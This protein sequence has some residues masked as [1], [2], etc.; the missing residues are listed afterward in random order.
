MSN[1]SI[2]QAKLAARIHDP[3]E[4]AL[5]LLRDPAGHEGGTVRKLREQLFPD[6]TWRPFQNMVKQADHWASAADRPQFPMDGDRYAAWT[7]V[8]FADQPEI[9]HPLT[10]ESFDPGTLHELEPAALKAISTDSFAKLV[11]RDGDVIAW[12]KTALAFWRFG[13]ELDAKGLKLLWQLL[14]ADTRVPDHTIWSHLD[15]TSALA[16]AMAGDETNTP[17]LLTVSFGPVQ[18]F[19]AQARSTSDLWAGSHLL[20]R[21]VWE[22]IRVI[23]ERLGPD[24]LLFPQLFGVP[25]VDA[26]ITDQLGGW[27]QGVAKADWQS[28]GTDANP[29]FAAALPNRFVAIVPAAQAK[30]IAEAVRDAA[31][32]WVM[33]QGEIM[34]DRLLKKAEISD[35][36]NAVEQV[37]RQLADFPE[38][39]WSAVPWSLAGE[40]NGEVQTDGLRDALAVFY[41]EAEAKSF[42][43][44]KA[45]KLLSKD[46]KVDG[47]WF[48]RPNAGVLYPPLYDLLERTQASVKTMRPFSPQCEEGYRCTLC[49]E[50]EW[51][52]PDRADLMRPAKK[53]QAV[54]WQK[55]PSSWSRKGKE[56]LCALCALK[57]LWPTLFADE[58]KQLTGKEDVPRFVVSTHTMA[59]AGD[60]AK[61]K[62]KDIQSLKPLFERYKPERVALPAK[63][64]ADMKQTS[65]DLAYIPGL[66]DAVCD[67]DERH[68]VESELKEWLGHKPETYYGFILFDGDK[69]GAWLQG[70]EDFTKRTYE[71]SWHT[72]VRDSVRE[73]ARHHPELQRY[74]K[75]NRPVSPARHAAISAALNGFALHLAR[76]AVEEAHHGKLIYAG[77]DDVMAMVPVGELLSCMRLLRLLYAGHVPEGV[78]LP[79]AMKGKVGSGFVHYRQRLLRVMGRKATASAGA[80]V[81]HHMMPLQRL[82]KTLRAAESEAKNKG[83]RDAF[84]LKVLKRGGGTVGSTARWFDESPLH[85]NTLS[86]HPVMMLEVLARTLASEQL[87]RRA[88][89]HV[90]AQLRQL[91]ER[92]HFKDKPDDFET[93]LKA[94]LARQF[95]QQGGDEQAQELAK[96]I[97][98][99]ACQTAKNNEANWLEEFF[100]VAEFLGREGRMGDAV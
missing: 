87:S 75:E 73:K 65:R 8:R 60:L 94:T 15:L 53:R 95:R 4:K 43:D 83:G 23:C 69:M 82:L 35:A 41:P 7:Q 14:P 86:K 11:Y 40:K 44:G 17:A 31:R 99:L 21:M 74:L 32:N 93:M 47:H 19:I 57:R 48:Y 56:H 70:N 64:A 3:A 10:G 2:W 61:N 45:W 88:A 72:Q 91:P 63:L 50:R 71:E 77:G 13:P 59:L 29:L 78:P 76:F 46:I 66:L 97:A 85:E 26:W 5:V 67:D 68:A 30:E 100:A 49:G 54:L 81:A 98:T 62:D 42:L 33:R 92:H 22:G 24:A 34:L 96:C 20:S 16:G 38:C 12:K 37:R 79:D 84:C 25:Q 18:S 39:H 52:T 55:L 27:P 90:Q 1:E 80:V 89:Y 51:L 6:E 36:G 28:K 9:K 58:V